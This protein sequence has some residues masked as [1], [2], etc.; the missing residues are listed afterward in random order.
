MLM[1]SSF[2]VSGLRALVCVSII[3]LGSQAAYGGLE[4]QVVQND[5]GQET[6]YFKTQ[7]DPEL[8]IQAAVRQLYPSFMYYYDFSGDNIADMLTCGE[9]QG[10]SQIRCQTKNSMTNVVLAGFNILDP[11]YN[12]PTY[13]TITDFD[14]NGKLESLACGIRYAD[15]SVECQRNN[16]AT[17]ALV[18]P[19]FQA[20]PPGIDYNSGFSMSTYA[21]V[22]GSSSTREISFC[23]KQASN[24]QVYC[25]VLN[26]VTRAVMAPS[27]PVLTRDYEL[28]PWRP[29][30]WDANGDNKSELVACARN[31]TTGQFACQIKNGITGASIA[32]ITV[33]TASDYVQAYNFG[34]YDTA[35]P[36]YEVAAC[37]WNTS[38]KQPW[39]QI[40][41]LNNT[42]FKTIS[43]ILGPAYVP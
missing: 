43:P 20:I 26:P 34:Q 16:P 7:P 17:G 31:R 1:K 23:W 6:L 42:V 38:T 12:A 41:K 18:G 37:G 8:S 5:A 3:L 33:M 39:C 11:G 4:V 15:N 29:S 10:T 25:R 22:D 21:D 40:K 27:T 30:Y 19:V 2:A 14:G 35:S 28:Y 13:L 24:Q 9:H 36:P 32:L